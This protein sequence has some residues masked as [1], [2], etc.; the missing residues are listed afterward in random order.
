[1]NGKDV[2]RCVVDQIDSNQHSECVIL[3]KIKIKTYAHVGMG[4]P[5]LPDETKQQMTATL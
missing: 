4:K 3:L 1:M 5:K 2:S